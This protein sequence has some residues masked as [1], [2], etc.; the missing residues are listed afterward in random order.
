ME[1]E[2]PPYEPVWADNTIHIS[3]YQ[4]RRDLHGSS[5]AAQESMLQAALSPILLLLEATADSVDGRMGYVL[6]ILALLAASYRPGGLGPGSLSYRSHVEDFFT[7]HDPSGE[8][9]RRFADRWSAVADAVVGGLSGLMK[10]VRDGF[11]VGQDPVLRAWAE[12]FALGWGLGL[13]LAESGSITEEPALLYRGVAASINSQALRKWEYSD[14][15]RYG[16]FH[17]AMRSLNFL[18]QR[19]N[20]ANFSAYRWLVNLLYGLLPL[21][22]ISPLERCFLGFAMAEAAETL[23]GVSWQERFRDIQEGRPA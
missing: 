13:G 19:V 1:L 5:L 14:D 21:L 8:V 15:G 22:D 2:P 20:V 4:P 18:P 11:Y 10:D 3:P 23:E 12:L 7:D 6:S 17:R 9:R 16:E